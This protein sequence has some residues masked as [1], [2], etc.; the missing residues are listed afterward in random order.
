MWYHASISVKK[1]RPVWTFEQCIELVNK[2]LSDH[3][4]ELTAWPAYLQ[5]EIARLMYANWIYQRLSVEPIRKPVLTHTEPQGLVVDCGD[6]RI[7]AL[8]A[9]DPNATVGVVCT[10][11]ETQA[12]QFVDW[13]RIHNNQQLIAVSG[14]EPHAQVLVRPAEQDHYAVS[15]LEIGDATTMHH[16]H[17]IDLRL[18]MI[19]IYL[20]QQPRNYR[21]TA[22]WIRETIDWQLY[23]MQA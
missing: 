9:H 15:W 3:G 2:K 4:S 21:F 1:L 13:T 6:T 14:F 16:L 10:A 23:S 18:R 17:S 8:L 5:D 7:M 20:D 12:S 22:D 11:A 19:Q